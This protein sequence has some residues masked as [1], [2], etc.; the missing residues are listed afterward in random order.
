MTRVNNIAGWCQ[1]KQVMSGS[2]DSRTKRRARWTIN[3]FSAAKGFRISVALAP[4]FCRMRC[5]AGESGFEALQP[6]RVRYPICGHGEALPPDRVAGDRAW[7]RVRLAAAGYRDG[8]QA[9]A[10]ML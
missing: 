10:R 9:S 4:S 2:Q 5:T 6:P 8:P 3:G 7:N 1:N